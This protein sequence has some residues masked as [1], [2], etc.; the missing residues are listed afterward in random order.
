MSIDKEA[1][2][3][4]ENLKKKISETAGLPDQ[5]REKL[6]LIVQRLERMANL[7]HYAQEFDTEATYIETVTSIPWD[8]RTED[9]L[10]LQKTKELMDKT[11]Y[12]MSYVKERI[13]EYLATL[14]LLKQRGR[15]AIANSPIIL[16]VG[17]QGVG[18]TTLAISMAKALGREF[19]RISMGGIGSTL[20]LRG[21]NKSTPSAEPGQIVKAL[22]KSKV[23]NPLILLDEIDKASG[24]MGLRSD[25]MAVLL[26]ILDPNQNSEF[27]DHYVDYPIDL[28]E[29]LFVCSAN[30]LGT[31]STALMDRMEIIKMPSYTDGEKLIIARDF[32]LPKAIET[33]GLNPGELDIDANIWPSIIRPFGYDS[34][35]R[36]LGRT[37]SSI[38]RKVA[39]EIVE[40]KTQKVVLTQENL[41]YYLPQ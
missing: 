6:F 29:V 40:G 15:D 7:G 20:E 24:E 10:D 4:L 39:K 2:Q 33:A 36:S 12:G 17:L 41:K 16:M 21:R 14:I 37:L 5:L 18:K 22:M 30:T 19:I 11:H 28:S 3:E 31:L 13:Q 35:I 38:C 1:I 27:R 32:I 8:K 34:G 25:I 23:R 26:E 9:H